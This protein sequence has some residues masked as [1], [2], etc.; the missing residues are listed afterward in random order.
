MNLKLDVLA[1]DVF[2]N[3]KILQSLLLVLV[4]QSHN[5]LSLAILDLVILNELYIVI[6]SK[7]LEE[8]HKV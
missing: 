6:F 2:E 5:Q 8:F 7:L 4:S 3:Y 1:L